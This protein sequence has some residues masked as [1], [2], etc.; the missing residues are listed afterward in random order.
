MWLDCVPEPMTS[1]RN[2]PPHL[3]LENMGDGEKTVSKAL[4]YIAFI[5]L[6]LQFI[7]QMQEEL[8]QMDIKCE[9]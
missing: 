8:K 4:E 2:C 3:S 6:V 7:N 1:V 5:S 9:C